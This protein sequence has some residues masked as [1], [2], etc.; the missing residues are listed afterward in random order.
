MMGYGWTGSCCGNGFL[1]IW[2]FAVIFIVVFLI[3]IVLLRGLFSSRRIHNKSE[4]TNS[5]TAREI[6]NERYAK[7]DISKKEYELMKKDL[8]I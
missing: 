6:L 8:G 7:G 3:V 4:K 2:L 1:N 5:S